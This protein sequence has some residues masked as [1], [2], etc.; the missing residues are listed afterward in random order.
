MIFAK[1]VGMEEN[2]LLLIRTGGNDVEVAQMFGTRCLGK[3]EL[4]KHCVKNTF[5]MCSLL[6]CVNIGENKM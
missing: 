6:L 5:R 3:E 4:Y 2:K 1:A